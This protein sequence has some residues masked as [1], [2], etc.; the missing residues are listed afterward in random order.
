MCAYEKRNESSVTEE[1]VFD[2]ILRES[3]KDTKIKIMT[4]TTTIGFCGV[5]V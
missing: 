1:V 2:K 4:T 5:C 3:M